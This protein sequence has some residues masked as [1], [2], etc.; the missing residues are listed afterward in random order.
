LKQQVGSLKNALSKNLTAH[1]KLKF[2]SHRKVLDIK[3]MKTYG[4]NTSSIFETLKERYRQENKP[5]EVDFRELVPWLK[6]GDQFSHQIHPYPAKLL[7]HI[8]HFFTH[9]N[10]VKDKRKKILD[11]FCGSGTVALETS[12]AGFTPLVAD[13]NPLALL[14]A[15]VKCLPYDC[16]QLVQALHQL[17]A[18]TKRLKTAPSIAIVNSELWYSPVQKR[19]LEIILR[20]I[21]EIEEGD[22]QDFFRVCFSVLTR[23]FSFADPAISVPV[24]LR[25]KEKFSE[26]TNEK[27]SERLSWLLN[28]DPLLEFYKICES[29][30]E[31]VHKTNVCFPNR[32]P[33][34]IAGTDARNLQFKT[35]ESS[36]KVPQSSVPLIITS[37]PY[38]SAQKY[39][40]AS[41]LSLNWLGFAAPNSLMNLE[42]QSIGREHL[43]RAYDTVFEQVL[44]IR[45]EK[46]I[47][48]INK[49]N[50]MRGY[51]TQQYL[52]DMKAALIEMARVISVEGRIIIVIGNNQVSGFPLRNDEFIIEIL[53]SYGLK[54]ELD[55]IDHIKSRGLMTKR[56]KTASIISR[57]SVLVFTK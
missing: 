41:S 46:L 38:G 20:A 7:P 27:I 26:K 53:T 37:P 56:N 47:S 10:I 5:I 22:I 12:L 30:I 52:H 1:F 18:R 34:I 15:K 48:E 16:A 21:L 24:R 40:R 23:R 13:A 49:I 57:E 11:P 44:P 28:S 8:A 36:R 14:I 54:L 33:I 9:S 45:F 31:R 43:G 51:I 32:K 35:K 25:E 17:I 4:G 2:R 19:T 55:L 42:K 50:P 29:N 6:I 39:I 3:I